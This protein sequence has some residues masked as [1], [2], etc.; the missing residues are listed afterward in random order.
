MLRLPLLVVVLVLLV[1]PAV[2]LVAPSRRPTARDCDTKWFEQKLDHWGFAATPTDG[3]PL[4]FKQRYLVCYP[5]GVT[6]TTTENVFFYVGNEA[7]V[8]LY[9]NDTGLMWE[10]AATFKAV[11]V[12]A[13]HRYFGE[14]L[15]FPGEPMPPPAKLKYLNPDQAMVDYAELIAALRGDVPSTHQL[16]PQTAAFIGFGGSYGATLCAWHKYKYPYSLTGCIAGSSPLVQYSAMHPSAD[17]DGFGKLATFD[18]SVAGGAKSDNCKVNINRAFQY[19]QSSVGSQW[20]SISTALGLCSPMK[21][22][23]DVDNVMG[24]FAGVFGY[25]AMGSYPYPSSYMMMGAGG[26]LPAYPMRVAC[27]TYLSGVFTSTSELLR[28]FSSAVKIYYN[29]AAG[30]TIKCIDMNSQGSPTI[31]LVNYL[32]GY[33]DCT[34]MSTV[35]GYT[36]DLAN[37]GDMFYSDPWNATASIASCMSEYNVSQDLYWPEVGHGGWSIVRDATNIVF[38]NG[39]LDPWRAGGISPSDSAKFGLGIT[40]LVVRGGGHHMDLM[41]SEPEDVLTNVAEVRAAEMAQVAKWITDHR[42]KTT[43]HQNTNHIQSRA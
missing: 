43:V 6:P 9:A 21:S 4:T 31:A 10:N 1:M 24:T 38:S 13:E 2:A 5:T 15:P 22:S 20:V 29:T 12:F 26:K 27:D 3:F 42:A 39:E 16:V 11:L 19:M 37:G 18:A 36:G 8:E 33:L 14:S 32:W 7:D 30:E 28:N 34:A 25:Y 17:S 23:D 41:F 40:A 35:F